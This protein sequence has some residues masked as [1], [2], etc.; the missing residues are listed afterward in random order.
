MSILTNKQAEELA[1]NT[2]KKALTSNMLRSWTINDAIEY[3]NR[4][5]KW[6]ISQ[7]FEPM[8]SNTKTH[9]HFGVYNGNKLIECTSMK[10]H[11][12]VYNKDIAK[13]IICAEHQGNN[14]VVDELEHCISPD[15]IV[16]GHIVKSNTTDKKLIVSV[17]QESLKADSEY[18]Y[19]DVY[20]K[21]DKYAVMIDVLFKRDELTI[22]DDTNALY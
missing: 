21:D 12:K 8:F 16:A 2:Y 13:A 17:A 14:E 19:V 7:G 10:V 6:Y 15:T 3:Y 4:L 11:M 1:A 9:A 20:E 18:V 5:E 22:V